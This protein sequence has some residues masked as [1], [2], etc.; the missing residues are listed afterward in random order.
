MTQFR[1]YPLSH[2][3]KDMKNGTRTASQASLRKWTSIVYALEAIKANIGT[4]C[5]LCLTHSK[6]TGCPL[7]TCTGARSPYESVWKSTCEAR[8]E[9]SRMLEYIREQLRIQEEIEE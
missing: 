9:A 3:R 5:G 6:C 8:E 4:Y 7:V 2:A 1:L